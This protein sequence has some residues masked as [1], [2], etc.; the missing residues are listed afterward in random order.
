MKN[1]LREIL[2]EIMEAPAPERKQEFLCRIGKMQTVT[3]R[4]SY[5]K[6]V[7][8]QFFY[9]GK[10]GWLIS[11]L[12]FAGIYFVCAATDKKVLWAFSA[13]VPFLAVSFLA[14]SLRS[15]VCEMA[16]LEMATRFSLR[17]L[18]MARME[19]M[20]FA[21]LLLLGLSVFAGHW[22]EGMPLLSTGVYLLVP[23]LLTNTA[24]LYLARRVRGRE[25]LYAVLAVAVVIAVIPQIAKLLYEEELFIWWL[26]ALGILSV[27]AAKEWKRNMERWEEYT[28]SL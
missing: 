15:E 5:G 28:W 3:S 7:T 17:S 13:M 14:E 24:G 16:E 20:G 25:C 6:F 26:A 8:S 12:S 27:L 11:V 21:H 2:K 22:L 9:I 1:E 19:I 10:R 23:Y 18:I 4:I